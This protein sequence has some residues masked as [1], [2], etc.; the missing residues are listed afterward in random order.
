MLPKIFHDIGIDDFIEGGKFYKCN[1]A[2][3]IDNNWVSEL[4]QIIGYKRTVQFDIAEML[5]YVK[6]HER[7]I[8]ALNSRLNFI[9]IVVII[10]YLLY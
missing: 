5:K 8:I 3:N 7:S 6:E 4:S 2:A 10:A 1:S 9:N